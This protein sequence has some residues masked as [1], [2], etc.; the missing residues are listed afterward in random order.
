MTMSGHH[1]VPFTKHYDYYTNQNKKNR[2][3][4]AHS[5]RQTR[6]LKKIKS[7]NLKDKETLVD[8][9]KDGVQML[10]GS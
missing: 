1:F 6:I 2:T 3:G 4:R 9:G 10:S 8:F 7:T 5:N